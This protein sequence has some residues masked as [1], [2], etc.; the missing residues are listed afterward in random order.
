[1]QML[2][3]SQW[4]LH[5]KPVTVHAVTSKTPVKGANCPQQC[6]RR[7]VVKAPR[8]DANCNHS[9]FLQEARPH[10]S[11]RACV[12]PR[13]AYS[14]P[15]QAILTVSQGVCTY[16]VFG[17][18]MF[19]V[20]AVFG[21]LN[22]TE[23]LSFLKKKKK[24]WPSTVRMTF[25]QLCFLIYFFTKYN[26]QCCVSFRCTAKWFSYIYILFFRFFNSFLNW[27]IVDWQCCRQILRQFFSF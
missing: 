8:N 22:S 9:D 13:N 26:L 11:R 10:L 1:M 6:A 7:S 3:I 4:Q 20:I 5:C 23:L 12:L 18:K 24:I 17:I 25:R 19:T 21:C 2:N 14:F 27:S 16:F 15:S